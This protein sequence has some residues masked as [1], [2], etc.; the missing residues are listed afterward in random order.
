MTSLTA[1]ADATTGTIRV[2]IEQTTLRDLF[3]RVVANGWGSPTAGPAW[4]T[5]GGVAGDYAVNGTQG[6][7]TFSATNSP[8]R[9]FSL[10]AADADMGLTGQVTIAVLALTQPIQPGWMVRY[11]DANNHYFVEVSLAPGGVATMNLRKNVLGVL[12]TLSS[13]VLEQT[14]AAGATWLARIEVC[15]HTLKAKAWRS[16]VTEPGWLATVNDFDL[17]TG[18]GLGARSVL[19]TG[20]TN[21]STVFAY[22]NFAAYVS[23]PVRLWRVLPDGTR[24]EVRGSPGSTEPATAAAATATATFYDNEAPFDT[25]VFY[26]LTS[27]CSTV[28]E[29]TSNTVNLASNGDGWLR[30]PVDP[31][32]NLRI[33]MESFFDECVDVD[34]LVWGGLGSSQY[35]NA[36]GIFDIIDDRRPVTV[37]QTRKNKASAFRLTSFTLDDIDFLEDIFDPGRILLLSLPT[38]QNY[39]WAHRSNGSDY[40]TCFD[41]EHD[42]I[43]VDQGVTTRAWQVPFRLSYAPVDTSEGGTGGNGIGGAGAT[44]DDLAAS[45]LGLT[46]NSLTASGETYLQVAQGVGY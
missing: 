34:T 38:S 1:A 33:V 26:E 8:R 14:H 37:S 11:T 12:T 41:V 40:I 4:S 15:G 39:G 6:T 44:Y 7:H 21:G 18:Q 23:Q 22:D 9:T 2:D 25:N 16:T 30:D 35:V 46:Y 31:T 24:T 27:D 32:R 10:A 36:S 3:T 28:V 45:A 19:A 42:Y 20:N 17:T 29:A 5:S 13:V 43:G